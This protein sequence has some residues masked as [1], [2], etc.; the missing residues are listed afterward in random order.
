[1]GRTGINWGV[2]F[3]RFAVDLTGDG[4][5]DVVGFGTDGVWV[6]LANGQ[7]G[8]S[9]PVF[10]PNDS[11]GQGQF[12]YGQ[13]WRTEKHVRTLANLVPPILRITAR[14]STG[15]TA[16]RVGIEPVNVNPIGG[17][18][19]GGTSPFLR[20]AVPDIV[21][22]GDAGVWTAISNRDGSFQTAKFVIADFGYNQGWRTDVHERVLA[23]LNGD[24]EADF[25]GFGNDGVWTALGNGD[26]TFAPAR[27][28]LVGFN[29]TQGW[30][31]SLHP[32]F[33][34]DLTGNG[35][36]DI[37]GFGNDG[38]WTA[39]GNGDGTVAAAKFVIADFGYN[40]GWRTDVHER[41]L[42]DLNGDRKADFVGFGND[43]VWTALGNG[44]GTFAPARMVLVGFNATQGWKTSLHPRFAVDLTGNGHA[45]IIGFGD[46]GVWTALGNGDGTFAAAKYVLANFGVNQGWTVDNHPRFLVDTTGDGRPDIVGFGDAGVW[47]AKNNGDG[48][49]GEA[50]FVLNDFGH[51]SGQTAIK[52]IFVL[53]MEN[54][55]FDHLLGFAPVGG[56]DTQTG[57]PTSSAVLA[58]NESNSDGDLP[59]PRPSYTVNRSAGDTTVGLKDV[60]HQ[61]TDVT[62]Q[63]TGAEYANLNG[64]PYPA[65]NNTGFVT[66]YAT[67]SD[68]TNPGEPMRCFDPK[69]VPVLHQ[70]ASEFVLCDNWHASMA[71]PTEPNRMFA[72]AAT[73]GLWDDSPSH[74]DQIKAESFDSEGIG[75]DTGTIYDKMRAGNVPFRIY[76]GDGVPNVVLLKGIG[77]SDIDLFE[78]FERDVTDPAY[79]A[80][81]TF[82][83]PYYGTIDQYLAGLGHSLKD[84]ALRL[85]VE[86]LDALL[87]AAGLLAPAGPI[88]CQH[89]PASLYDGETFI[90]QVY[91][92]IRKSPHWNDSMLIL[93]WDEHGGF[94]DHVLPPRAA[95]TGSR[96]QAHGYVF[97]Q[98][99]PRVPAVVISP[100]CEKNRIEHRRLEHAA[101]PATVEQVF[102]LSPMTVRD[103]SIVGVQNLATLATPRQDTPVTLIDDSQRLRA[104]EPEP[105]D[106]TTPPAIDPSLP[107]SSISD[108]WLTSTI[109]IVAKIHMQSVPAAEAAQIQTRVQGLQTVGDFV[110]YL[111]DAI[112]VVKKQ[113]VVE[114]QLRVARRAAGKQPAPPVAAP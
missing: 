112:P 11:S 28:V 74:A 89:P 65:V 46:D 77:L 82:I 24:R 31:T 93:L 90:K 2:E 27:M 52:H 61:F 108:P 42:A 96:G 4:K 20:P 95:P 72:H 58:R 12:G 16:V 7:G 69:Y 100:L 29:A 43:G 85:A 56:T 54:R 106:N 49:F 99:G 60:Q 63:L 101:L 30:K 98:Y 92:I 26:G 114:R 1:M 14:E 50:T 113:Q 110:Q 38:V 70:L 39:L 40:Q 103:S 97:D 83:E 23:D 76:S 21:S 53:M 57:Q 34:V 64:G 13:E 10:V 109:F 79:D 105:G 73:S 37:I 55:S 68:K 5:A 48:T 47:V 81:F 107:L 88:N 41:V 44:D 91:E 80:A 8:F 86:A 36:A 66:D 67:F 22:F 87:R 15:E 33:A 35:H 111:N 59:E 75:F 78:D 102:G 3:P 84:D 62:I 32:R 25:V 51:Q 94:Y 104:P 19:L 6:S 45:D 18:S 71:G 9:T 17:T